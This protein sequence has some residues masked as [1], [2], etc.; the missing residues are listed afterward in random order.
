VFNGETVKFTYEGKLL[1]MGGGIYESVEITCPNCGG[2]IT[3]TRQ[4]LQKEVS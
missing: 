3:F 4:E 1:S 2:G